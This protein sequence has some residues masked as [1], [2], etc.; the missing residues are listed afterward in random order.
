MPPAVI[1]LQ[2]SEDRRDVV[3][4][5]VQ[6]L[7]E[8]HL[9]AFPTETGYSVAGSAFSPAAMSRLAS[10]TEGQTHFPVGLAVRSGEEAWDYVPKMNG[11]GRR[12]TRRAWPGPV[13]L[14]FPTSEQDSALAR[15]PA[16]SRPHLYA[17]GRLAL[18]MPGHRLIL[19]VLQLIVG[20]VAIANL[21]QEGRGGLQTAGELLALAG[22]RIALVVDDGPSR[23]E[24]APTYVEI[25]GDRFRVLRAGVILEQ[26]LRRLASLIIIF[27]CTGNT[28]RSPMA[29]QIA[30]KL[31]AERLG[32]GIEQL[33][34]RGVIVMSAGIAAMNGG[35]P[36]PEAVDVMKEFNLDLSNHASQPL[37]DQMIRQA[38]QLVVMTRSHRSAILAEYPEAADRVQLVCRNGAD[39]ADPIGGPVE[40][41]R[42]CAEQLDANLKQW[43]DEIDV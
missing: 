35:R 42:R 24:V 14:V 39:V 2:Q 30:R 1:D 26:T 19:D 34:Q 17:E 25:E 36:S 4:R 21:T 20:P 10:L 13:V 33:E 38:D 12:L 9:V 3:H 27:V 16:E 5:A 40:L 43:V 8:G 15:L 11:L 28:C 18:S 7:A 29:E 22:D 32:C 31:L 41:Y 23:Y 6:A 37:T